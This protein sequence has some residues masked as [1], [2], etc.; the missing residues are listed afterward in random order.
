MLLQRVCQIC[1]QGKLKRKI[2]KTLLFEVLRDFP[3]TIFFVND[4]VFD[5]WS[6]S[7]KVKK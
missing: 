6:K 4:E 7:E 1:W 2:K 5:Y 3:Q